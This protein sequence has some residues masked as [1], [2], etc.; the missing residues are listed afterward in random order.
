M[1]SRE[2]LIEKSKQQIRVLETVHAQY[3][4]IM[5]LSR[6]SQ[7]LNKFDQF[8]HDHGIDQ[9]H[10]SVYVFASISVS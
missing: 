4:A 8:A 10:F 1:L 6:I 9:L 2:V 5:A 7:K 3:L